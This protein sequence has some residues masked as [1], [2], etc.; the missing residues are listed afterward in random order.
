MLPY[1]A[2]VCL[3]LGQ[4]KDAGLDVKVTFKSTGATVPRLVEQLSQVAHVPMMAPAAFQSD[5]VAVRVKDAPLKD[6]LD[7]IGDLTA[8]VWEMKPEGYVL[9]RS[10]EKLRAEEAAELAYQV[11]MFQKQIDKQKKALANMQPWTEQ[12]AK[13][14]AFGLSD[15]QKVNQN[16]TFDSKAWQRIQDFDSKAPGGRA[17]ARVVANLQAKDLAALPTDYKIVFSDRP[18]RL[19]RP[20]PDSVMPALKNLVAEQNLWADVAGRIIGDQNGGMYSTAGWMKKAFRGQVGKV[21][22]TVAKSEN[23][24][25]FNASIELMVADQKGAVI[26]RGTQNLNTYGFDEE[27]KMPTPQAGEKEIPPSPFDEAVRSVFLGPGDRKGT[28]PKALIDQLVN[29][30]KV[31]PLSI[32]AGDLLVRMAGVQDTNMVACLPDDAFMTGFMAG[33]GKTTPSMLLKILGVYLNVHQGD[34]W[35]TMVSKMPVLARSERVD[36]AALGTYVRAVYAKGHASL[37]DAAAYAVAAPGQMWDSLGFVLSM[38]IAKNQETNYYDANMLRFY[39][40]LEPFQRQTLEKGGALALSSLQPALMELV[41][42]MVFGENS[43]IQ[44]TQDQSSPLNEDDWD[45]FYNGLSREPTELFA[46]GLPANS[47][48]KLA[49]TSSKVVMSPPTAG[50]NGIM[51]GSQD[52]GPEEIAQALYAKERPG[53]FPWLDQQTPF[54]ERKFTYGTRRSLN[55]TFQFG[56]VATLAQALQDMS[57]DF[58]EPVTYDKLPSDFR[59][60]VADRLA[61]IRK[62]YANVKPGQFGNPVGG[63][64][65][66]PPP[67]R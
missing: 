53:I 26:V 8:G 16:G 47:E 43:N 41:N 22:L 29:P 24:G 65:T 62:E 59:K 20:M 11:G 32:M 1:V 17:I 3:M 45:S 5:I 2:A 21:L 10:S 38:M 44:P 39:A 66:P 51:F 6:L 33:Q 9:V 23:G 63:Q 49:D 31:E 30:E 58:T 34:G 57:Y 18:N 19:Q 25:N 46:Q 50:P 27:F 60:L 48:L 4:A 40:K 54:D 36:R 7:R 67:E 56:K 28:L 64:A 35:V 61:E 13:S 15:A 52:M 37:D 14:V 55:F 12:E 42:K